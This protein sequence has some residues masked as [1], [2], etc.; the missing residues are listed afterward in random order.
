MKYTSMEVNDHS[1]YTLKEKK[2]LDSRKHLKHER[3]GGWYVCKLPVG[4]KFSA[5]RVLFLVASAV[6]MEDGGLAGLA[7]ELE[8]CTLIRRRFQQDMSWL[9]RPI[10]AC[11]IDPEEDK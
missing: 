4:F 1:I 2:S 7:K 10:P 6:A 9:Q 3:V 11:P 5:V 8:Q